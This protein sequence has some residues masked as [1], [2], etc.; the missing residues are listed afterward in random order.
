MLTAVEFTVHGISAVV[1]TVPI[2]P[3]VDKVRFRMQLLHKAKQHIL[4][5]QVM[6]I[7]AEFEVS[8]LQTAGM[9][10]FVVRMASNSTA[11]RKQR[12]LR[13]WILSPVTAWR[14]RGPCAPPGGSIRRPAAAG[15]SA[16]F[17]ARQRA[18]FR[19]VTGCRIGRDPGRP[20]M[21]PKAPESWRSSS[22]RQSR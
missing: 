18:C 14:A 19:P 9:D 13:S 7:D 3:N 22:A 16:A 6:V 10:R 4:P 15:V 8:E 2:G 21:A 1:Q 12:F 11:R 17:R 20:E 5:D